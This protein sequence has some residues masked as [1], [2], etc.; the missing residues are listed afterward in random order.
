MAVRH[1]R[2]VSVGTKLAGATLL[3][4]GAVTAAAYHQ[5]S[6]HETEQLLSA[7]ERAATMVAELFTAGLS[8]PLAF[9]DEQGV[10]EQ[11]AMVTK[12]RSVIDAS[13][14]P[15]A[16]RS[17][18]TSMPT[19]VER[20]ADSVIVE[21]PVR[22]ALGEVL[23]VA[24]LRFS[25]EDERAGIAAAR[26]RTLATSLALALALAFVIT[27]LTRTLV[28][29][30]LARLAE[31]AKRI[32]EG[33][34]LAIEVD[35]HD[36]LGS[37]ARAFVSMGESIARRE[38]QLSAR[39]R[40]MRR[41]L[42]NVAEGL[43]TVD[44]DGRVSDE[45]SRVLDDWFGVPPA[46]R[47][48]FEYFAAFAPDV[49][50]ALRLGWGEL[51]DD[52]MPIEVVLDQMPHRFELRGRFFEMDYLP[53]RD[54]AE[55]GQVLIVVRDVSA[56]VE[57]ERAERGQR[58]AMNVFRRVLDDREGFDEFFAE[59]TRLVEAICGEPHPPRDLARWARD[60]HTLKGNAA[61]YGLDR[62][63]ER[64][65]A[66]ESRLAEE[67]AAPAALDLA[68]LRAHWSEVSALYDE[69]SHS[70]GEERIELRVEEFAAHLAD[71]EY[72]RP[73]YELVA[74]VRS[75][76]HELAYDRL[77]RI[78]EQGRAL[79]RRL[80]K[81]D[82]TIELEVSP[83]NLRLP[84]S[85]WRSIWTSFAHVLRNTFDHGI[86]TREERAAAGKRESARVSIAIAVQE[87]GIELAVSDDGRGIAWEKIR[88][89]ALARGL[90]CTTSA[91]LEEAL[92]ADR[93][94]SREEITDISGRGVGMGAVREAVVAC[95]GH[96]SAE[97]VS[98]EGTTL[99]LSFPFAMLGSISAPE[100]GWET[101][102]AS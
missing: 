35:A 91:E 12:S 33:G 86:E 83:R 38:S 96:I 53:I 14:V 7:K 82:T 44:K 85:R 20:H 60:L 18:P 56:R 39:N 79:A 98:G 76:A 93:V 102:V 65:H 88:E 3:V 92:Y 22:G 97:S 90:P 26:S 49:A 21:R 30:R 50:S 63:S 9:D 77:R 74:T 2:F 10:R 41:V 13:V 64:C 43:L 32:E 70:S 61:L 37:L 47:D 40:D 59:A 101:K 48:V 72:A 80:G 19:R 57:R 84:A 11:I 73:H 100:S 17:R 66:I 1:T 16:E 8:A 28:V 36:E 75:W 71:I 89:S 94:S 23:G 68:Q 5:V 78:A 6:A 29:R 87:K 55:L 34:R 52:V 4:L 25:L 95:G 42:D 45:R 69:L 27:F 15:V 51:I 24:R 99:R 81:A 67:G 31:G 58:E 46:S 54:G 62:L